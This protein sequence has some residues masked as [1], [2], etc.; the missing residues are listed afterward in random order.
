MRE[1]KGK[2][3]LRNYTMNDKR[4]IAWLS[5]PKTVL[6]KKKSGMRSRTLFLPNRVYLSKSSIFC[7]INTCL[8]T[9]RAI[10]ANQVYN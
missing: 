3:T 7:F 2:A 6:E 9:V 5:V 1:R 4:R 8:G 10:L